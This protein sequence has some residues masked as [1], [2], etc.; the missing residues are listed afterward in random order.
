MVKNVCG[1]QDDV[2]VVVCVGLG[3]CVK[4]TDEHDWKL[5]AIRSHI[6]DSMTGFIYEPMI[7]LLL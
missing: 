1:G 3:R 7:I 4:C 5:V 6:D 2:S